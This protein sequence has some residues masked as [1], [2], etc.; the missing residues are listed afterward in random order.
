MVRKDDVVVVTMTM[1]KNPKV[2]E[3]ILAT[4][5]NL[6]KQGYNNIIAVDDNSLPEMRRKAEELGVK[7]V[8]EIGHGVTGG[9]LQAMKEGYKTGKPIIA[10]TEPDKMNFPA[11]LDKLVKPIQENKADLTIA[12][13]RKADFKQLTIPQRLAEIGDNLMQ[14]IAIEKHTDAASGPRVMRRELA[15]EFLEYG[16]YVNMKRRGFPRVFSGLSKEQKEMMR[17]EWGAQFYGL[18]KLGRHGHRIVDVPVNMPY[19]SQEEEKLRRG[20][21]LGWNKEL[22]APRYRLRQ[23]RQAGDGIFLGIKNDKYEKKRMKQ[24]RRR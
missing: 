16:N 1:T 10:Y 22:E 7:F 11:N 5:R 4:F 21:G 13:R 17:K 6:K 18:T 14:A 15:S 9:M 2:A 23:L 20:K 24:M 19:P 8:K 12:K 3:H